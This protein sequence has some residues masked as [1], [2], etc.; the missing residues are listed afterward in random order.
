MLMIRTGAYCATFTP[1]AVSSRT[2]QVA[3]CGSERVQAILD[4]SLRIEVRY[5][6]QTGGGHRER[7]TRDQAD[8]LRLFQFH[9]VKGREAG[10]FFVDSPHR[11]QL[12]VGEIYRDLNKAA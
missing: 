1:Y 4:K 7:F 10:H 6:H 12:E 8:K 9:T 5:L 11:S 3:G 2:R